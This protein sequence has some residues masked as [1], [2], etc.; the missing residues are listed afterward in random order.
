MKTPL[1]RSMLIFSFIAICILGLSAFAFRPVAQTPQP[2]TPSSTEAPASTEAPSATQAPMSTE[3]PSATQA[4]MSTEAP[5]ATQSPAA[6]SAPSG[7]QISAQVNTNC[8]LGPNA[9]YPAVGGLMVG[10]TSIVVGK[11]SDSTW[12]LIQNTRNSSTDCW[13][14][15]GSTQVQGDAS[16]VKVAGAPPLSYYSPVPRYFPYYVSPFFPFGRRFF[17]PGF[18]MMPF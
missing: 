5:S 17:N 15:A 2:T 1:F 18:F 6:S 14:W 10:Q 8:R 9:A 16:S 4:P 11:S 3:A 12:W 7:P 13:V